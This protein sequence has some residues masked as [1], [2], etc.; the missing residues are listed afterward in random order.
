MHDDIERYVKECN[1]CDRTASNPVKELLHPWPNPE[2]SW[3][4]LHID[5]AGSIHGQWVLV[6]VD[7]YSKFVEARWFSTITSAAT[8]RYLRRLF[9]QYRSPEVLVLDNDT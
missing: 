4:R 7:S 3:S 5:F 2:K 6:I 1:H 8:C 9:S